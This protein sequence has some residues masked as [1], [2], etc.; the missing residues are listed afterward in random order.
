ASRLV[1]RMTSPAKPICLSLM[2]AKAGQLWHGQ[3]ARE[4][5]QTAWETKLGKQSLGN[6]AWETKLGKQSLGNKAWE[7][8]K[9]LTG[10]SFLSQK[11]E[12]LSAGVNLAAA[13]T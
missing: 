7:T 2:P 3:T 13:S 9:R 4:R 6:K 8:K 1:K 12:A 11:Q 5:N 10:E